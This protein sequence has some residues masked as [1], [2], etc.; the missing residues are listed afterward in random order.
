[1]VDEDFFDAGRRVQI[2]TGDMQRANRHA[3]AI[4]GGEDHMPPPVEARPL[5]L[6]ERI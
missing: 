6:E 3:T 2:D 5:T 4:I 1:V